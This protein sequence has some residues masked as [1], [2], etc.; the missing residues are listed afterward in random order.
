[1]ELINALAVLTLLA[2]LLVG[3]LHI[4]H[5]IRFF[6]LEEYKANRYF[7]VLWRLPPERRF[8]FLTFAALLV[9]FS[10]FV[11]FSMQAAA[12]QGRPDFT[13]VLTI[14]IVSVGLAMALLFLRP[15]SQDAKQKFNATPRA[16]R[17]LSTAWVLVAA[18]PLFLIAISHGFDYFPGNFPLLVV[19]TGSLMLVLSPLYLP[20]ANLIMWP[21]EESTRR[22]Y[23][24]L[25]RQNLQRSGATV[26]ALTGSYGKTSTKH[27]LQHI[28]E[29]KFRSLMTPRSYNTL[30]GISRVIND[31]MAGDERYDYFIVEAG[32]YI[33][34]EIARICQLVKPQI[35]VVT[36]VG[37]MHLERFGSLDNIV[38]AKYEI[39]EALPKDGVGVFNADDLRVLGMA[40]RGY[41]QT[42]LL[43]TQQGAK[44]ANLA[45]T[46]VQMT[47][48]GMIFTV[49]D[50]RTNEQQSM[51]MP[52]YGEHNVTNVLL[53]M[54]V[55]HHLGMTLT[56]I[57][58]RVAT[59]KPAEHRLVRTVHPNGIIV[60]DDAYSANP[61]GTQMAL[62]VLALQGSR[63]RVVVTSG[64]FE[65]GA[66]ADEENQSLGER[67]AAVATH[68][69]LIG[70]K[71]TAAV[72]RGLDKVGF[73]A[74]H[75]Y[76]V[77]TIEEAIAIYQGF[78]Q[79][80]DTL[81]VLTDLP[82]T[83]A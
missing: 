12:I 13:P 70:E 5:L 48:E 17:L 27:Y 77:G 75:I 8:I 74:D 32:A 31:V 58:A 80:G 45:A 79:A 81:L 40:Q 46:D 11:I 72:H 44:D 57:A 60:I 33:P 82:D 73:P 9:T 63:Q 69:L 6:Q 71:Q 37:P 55:A 22:Y 1:M 59:L 41:P 29:G 10:V 56:E 67:I 39:I 66:V 83:Y 62:K 64:M 35:S 24:R 21:V 36:T 23:L 76:V 65:L 14:L 34:G 30:L 3:W 26:I 50:T 51:S 25:A 54:A 47:A 7:K 16:R 19:L 43:V 18:I 28:L 49:T 4:Y 78:L 15:K 53:A 68:V 2:W 38:K 42:R 20:L 61:V 52:L